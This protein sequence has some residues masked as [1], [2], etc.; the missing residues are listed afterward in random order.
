MEIISDWNNIWYEIN[1]KA[2][3]INALLLKENY[4]GAEK[5]ALQINDI[6]ASIQPK[7]SNREIPHMMNLSKEI[8]QV[9]EICIEDRP[10]TASI[11]TISG[12]SSMLLQP[13]EARKMAKQ[14]SDAMISV[15]N[16]MI[17]DDELVAA[18]INK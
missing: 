11:T 9:I 7:Y 3:E 2:K 5:L 10:G 16:K 4:I 1:N 8:A 12:E 6:C 17:V 15:A 18:Y 13:E 14:I